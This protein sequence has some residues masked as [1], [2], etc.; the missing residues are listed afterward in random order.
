V[1]NHKTRVL[2]CV[3]C[4]GE[5]ND[6]YGGHNAEPLAKGRCCYDCNGEVLHARIYGIPPKNLAAA[7]G[8]GCYH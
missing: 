4:G 3:L 5:I 7:G 1:V 6:R 8:V 2:A